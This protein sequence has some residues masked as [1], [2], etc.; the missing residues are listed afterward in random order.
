MIWLAAYVDGIAHGGNPVLQK[1]A[2]QTSNQSANQDDERNA[3]LVE[4]YRLCQPFHWKWAVGV[5]LQIAGCMR[6]MSRVH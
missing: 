5:D 2:G 3:V 1:V 6:A 4:A